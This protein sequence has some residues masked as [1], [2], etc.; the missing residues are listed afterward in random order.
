VEYLE[1]EKSGVRFNLTHEELLRTFVS[2][3]NESKPFWLMGRLLNPNKVIEAVIFWSYEPADKLMLPNREALVAVRNKKYLVDNIIE[4]KVKGAYACTEK[5]LQTITM[6]PD[7]AETVSTPVL[8]KK[9]KRRII[10]VFGD[11]V[12]MKQAIASALNKLL[13]VPVIL[14]EEPRQGKK[15]IKSFQEEYEDVEF[16]VVL[17]TPDDVAYPRKDEFGKRQFR[18]RQDVIFVLGYLIGKLG[19]D[20]VLVFFKE[21]N[22]FKIP[23]DF[24]GV[25]AVAFDDQDSWKLALIRELI[26]NGYAV[27]GNRILK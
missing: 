18:S 7:P 16:A 24:D 26:D 9:A 5:F 20:N 6:K 13:L 1:A 22:N 14:S 19:T 25:K 2:P 8:S 3:M 11:D 17:L 15:I 10:V 21:R 23:T 4:S 12:E 27:E